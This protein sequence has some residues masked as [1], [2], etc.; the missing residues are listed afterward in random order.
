MKIRRAIGFAVLTYI[1]TM[2]IGMLISM[3][4]GLDVATM[5]NPPIWLCLISGGTAAIISGLFSWLYFRGKTVKKGALYG[6]FLGLYMVVLGFAMDVI[7]W[8]IAFP[9]GTTMEGMQKLLQYYTM[10]Y[11]WATFVL[12]L[13]V[14]TLTGK[15]SK[16][17]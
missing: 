2:I 5:A 8:A 4:L 13:I 14:T 10:R 1:T 12:I 6:F 7:M 15:W 11:F 9:G 17:A 3:G 16:K